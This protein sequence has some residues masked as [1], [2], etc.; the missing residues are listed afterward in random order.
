ML[1]NQKCTGMDAGARRYAP[2]TA[3]KSR[4]R[5]ASK[6]KRHNSYRFLMA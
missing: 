1:H 5:Q 2:W 6:T 3:H 4:F